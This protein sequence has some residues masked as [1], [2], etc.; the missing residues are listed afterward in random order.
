MFPVEQPAHLPATPRICRRGFR[1]RPRIL[2]KVPNAG[3]SAPASGAFSGKQFI[4]KP[5]EF[6]GIYGILSNFSEIRRRGCVRAG[7]RRNRPAKRRR[8]V[9]RRIPESAP[10]AKR[11]A[12]GL[13]FDTS[14]DKLRTT[15]GEVCIAAAWV[16]RKH[17][18]LPSKPRRGRIEGCAPFTRPCR[19]VP[20][21]TL[22]DPDPNGI[23]SQAVSGGT[24]GSM[25]ASRRGTSFCTVSHTISRFMSKYA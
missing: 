5:R 18:L 9:L 15:Q 2:G 14:F 8:I 17:P 11:P 20:S 22:V 13:P 23:R 10:D 24:S 16:K 3:G 21:M 6:I 4:G 19:T 1:S 25:R 12:R 7:R